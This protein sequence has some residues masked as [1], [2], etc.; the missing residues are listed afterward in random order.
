MTRTRWLIALFWIVVGALLLEQCHE[1]TEKAI[2]EGR[3][4][5]PRQ[6]FFTAPPG[7]AQ[8]AAPAVKEPDVRQT[9]FTVKEETPGPGSF[10]CYVT[11]RNFGAVHRPR[12]LDPG[13]AYRGVRYGAEDIGHLSHRVL[14]ETDPLSQYSASLSFPDLKPGE[15]STQPVVFLNQANVKPG[16]NP[17]PEI[18]FEV[19]K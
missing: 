14:A 19:A 8:P 6:Y 11:L 9:A 13:P 5:P 2:K 16:F 12:H 1:A 15:S 3:D 4:N 18:S 17:R 10:T 7:P